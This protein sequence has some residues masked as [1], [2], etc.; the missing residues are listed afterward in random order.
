MHILQ[1]PSTLGSP[2]HRPLC[3]YGISL[4]LMSRPVADASVRCRHT[5]PTQLLPAD[6]SSAA[7]KLGCS[8]NPC[9]AGSEIFKEI[10]DC[11]F[12]FSS[13]RK[14]VVF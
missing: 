14:T 1:S 2:F 9:A 3:P 11:K 12:P 4:Q 7:L 10:K 8:E 5:R 6:G 13:G